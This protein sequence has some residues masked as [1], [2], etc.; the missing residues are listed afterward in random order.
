MDT[1]AASHAS[2]PQLSAS[3]RLVHF[4]EGHK[5]LAQLYEWFM[6]L[7]KQHPSLEPLMKEGR[8]RPYLTF[9]PWAAAYAMLVK[10]G[11]FSPTMTPADPVWFPYGPSCLGPPGGLK[12][13]MHRPQHHCRPLHG[14]LLACPTSAAQCLDK[15]RPVLVRLLHSAFTTRPVISIPAPALSGV[16]QPPIPAT[17]PPVPV[18][19]R[20]T[21]N[22]TTVV[23][24]AGAAPASQAGMPTT[25][26]DM[27]QLLLEICAEYPN[28]PSRISPGVPTTS[29]QPAHGRCQCLPWPMEPSPLPVPD[30]QPQSVPASPRPQCLSQYSFRP[31]LPLIANCRVYQLALGPGK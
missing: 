27:M 20:T 19:P 31:S 3:R 13:P 14:G 7:L 15:W 6:A 18:P 26:Q 24:A 25:L 22:Y 29:P 5:T 9:N 17:W 2:L 4:S 10:K 12:T 28:L 23:G 11:F 1:D 8:C 21:P 30:N 16:A